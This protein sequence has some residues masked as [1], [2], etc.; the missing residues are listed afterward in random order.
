MIVDKA[1]SSDNTS[2]QL[3]KGSSI[4][5][6]AHATGRYFVQCFDKHGNLKWEDHIE[7]VVCT[8]GKNVVLDA[9]LAGSAYTVVGPYMGLVSAAADTMAQLAGTNGWREAGG[10]NAPTYSGGRKTCVF[11]AASAGAKALSAALS[12]T[13]T[14]AGT[15][16][17][18]FVILGTGALTTNDN[19]A[20]KLWSV[21]LFTGGDKVVASTD[22][23]NV[24][25]ST[26]L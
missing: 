6:G 10:T 18:C 1:N 26:S 16:K 7:N 21:G 2:A 24:S 22:V 14:G 8:E 11:S 9:A 23:L 15:V 19:T 20:G 13:F 4:N 17:G 3:V 12:F 5:E 25:Y